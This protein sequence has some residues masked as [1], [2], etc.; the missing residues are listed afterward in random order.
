MARVGDERWHFA[1]QAHHGQPNLLVPG[2]VGRTIHV[3]HQR[4]DRQGVRAV[5]SDR[6]PVDRGLQQLREQSGNG[7]L[8]GLGG[9]DDHQAGPGASAP[10]L[11]QAFQGCSGQLVAALADVAGVHEQQD[12]ADA[13]VTQQ[14]AGQ[15]C[16]CQRGVDEVF[17]V[18]VGGE[19]DMLATVGEDFSVAGEVHRQQVV[20]A[21]LRRAAEPA[22][23]FLQLLPGR[24]ERQAVVQA[25][26]EPV[27]EYA[28]DL[29]PG[30]HQAG[31]VPVPV[32]RVVRHRRRDQVPPRPVPALPRLCHARPSAIARP[33]SA[34]V[35]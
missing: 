24:A 17:R 15:L 16:G 3:L 35:R 20:L 19:E 18:G 29:V 10:G 21:P 2:E 7:L 25:V 31:P 11:A 28:N 13:G 32:L 5:S 30:L 12:S 4:V 33:H 27:G 26:A 23:G 1:V 6:Q 14:G 9:G 22:Q 34:S 8:V